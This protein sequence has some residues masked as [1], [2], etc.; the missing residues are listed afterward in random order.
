MPI[1]YAAVFGETKQKI[2]EHPKSTDPAA[3][4]ASPGGKLATFAEV[5]EKI[6]ETLD[7]A[8]QQRKTIE[9]KENNTRYSCFSN[10]EGRVIVAVS[11][12]AETP[13]RT[14]LAM[15]DAVEP[16]VRCPA[17]QLRN[18]KKLLQ[19]KMDFY[20]NP[21]NDKIAALSHDVDLVVETA[22]A[23]VEK[24]L[25][26]GELVDAL[27]AKSVTLAEQANNFKKVSTDVKYQFLMNNLKTIVLG[28]LAVMGGILLI[29]IVACKPDFSAC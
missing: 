21:Q 11:S 13:S 16:L 20:N 10:G 8:K 28:A 17:D 25:K 23:N 15:L 29:A 27:Q 19:M 12:L 5:S 6:V 9:D 1:F 2:A 18:G 24:A 7:P 3:I 22:A 26:R 14:T 4:A